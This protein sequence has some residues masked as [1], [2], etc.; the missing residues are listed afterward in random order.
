MT[1]IAQKVAAK[2]NIP[3]DAKDLPE[4]GKQLFEWVQKFY[5]RIHER[6]YNSWR[7]YNGDQW[8]KRRRP[9]LTQATYNIIGP[10]IDIIAANLTD[11]QIIYQM[12]PKTDRAGDLSKVW[13]RSM[14][15]AVEQDSFTSI[16]SGLIKQSLIKGYCAAKVTHDESRAVPTRYEIIHPLNFFT[17]PGVRRPEENS[18]FFWHIEWY[19]PHQI[20]ESWPDKWDEME[21]EFKDP[22]RTT[23][24]GTYTEWDKERAGNKNYIYG[25][26]VRELWLKTSVDDREPIPEEETN[27]KLQVELQEL[28]QGDKPTA[29]ISEDHDTHNEDHGLYEQRV[30]TEIANIQAQAQNIRPDDQRTQMMLAQRFAELQKRLSFTRAHIE[31]HDKMKAAADE[32]DYDPATR[33]KFNGWRRIVY[34]GDAYVVLN[35]D[36][37]DQRTPY[38]DYEDRGIHPFVILQSEDTANDIHGLSLVEKS[39]Y[40]QKAVNRWMSKFEDFLNTCAN[41]TLIV[42]ITRC[43]IDLA[44]I[45]GVAGQAIPVEGNPREVI[46][47]LSGPPVPNQF[48]QDVATWMRQIEMLTGVSDVELGQY[49]RMERASQ[50]FVQQLAFHGRARWRAHGRQYEDY[51][52][53]VGRKMQLIIQKYMTGE[54]QVT[55]ADDPGKTMVINRTIMQGGRFETLNDMTVGKWEV[56]LELKPMINQTED[57]KMETAIRLYTM[58]NAMGMPLLTPTAF[59]KMINDPILKE[60]AIEATQMWQQQ[61]AAQQAQQGGG[62]EVRRSA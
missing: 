58:Q 1:Q 29:I 49:P 48:L 35:S 22:N 14:Q 56:K 50:P 54:Q 34:G 20:R 60:S 25:C 3:D 17:E 61:M 7:F 43:P 24:A 19:S 32:L 4:F 33:P 59:A 2:Y 55:V 47:W 23:S 41:P 57:A 6:G 26:W 51:L 53:R 30:L 5:S 9:G 15:L 28:M 62:A 16:N 12:Y 36:T 10:H 37:D 45:Q 27:E 21:G 11:S 42:D 44:K 38:T 8:P 13:D 40:A 46:M 52:R 39:T 31:E 18:S